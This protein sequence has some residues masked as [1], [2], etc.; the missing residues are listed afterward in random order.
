MQRIKLLQ[1]NR[2]G[3]SST[4]VKELVPKLK[5]VPGNLCGAF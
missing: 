2:I 4:S 3:L 5:G 1:R